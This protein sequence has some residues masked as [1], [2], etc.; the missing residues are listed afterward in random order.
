DTEI[1]EL[2]ELDVLP[3]KPLAAIS[4]LFVTPKGRGRGWGSALLDTATRAAEHAGRGLML[5][6]VDDGR[7]PAVAVYEHL[8]WRLI[9]KL[10]GSW[11]L[12]DGTTPVLRYYLAP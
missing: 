11:T 10:D 8:G 1:T 5:S 6:V 9:A 7:S 12:P 3:G 2:S 4:R